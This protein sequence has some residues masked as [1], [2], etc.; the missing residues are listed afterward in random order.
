MILND[1][2]DQFDTNGPDMDEPD[3][4]ENELPRV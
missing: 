1:H 2:R 3:P 4:V